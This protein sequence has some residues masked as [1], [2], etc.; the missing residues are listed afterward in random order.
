[1]LVNLV[2]G[3]H[4]FSDRFA[5]LPETL[6]LTG[7]L[8]QHAIQDSFRLEKRGK[9][10]LKPLTSI[11]CLDLQKHESLAHWFHRRRDAQEFRRGLI[12][13]PAQALE[14]KNRKRAL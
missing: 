11:I 10:G 5:N 14:R 1:M 2:A 13:A 4:G 12:T 9:P 8:C 3:H 6:G 7:T